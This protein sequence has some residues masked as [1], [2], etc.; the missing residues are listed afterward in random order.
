MPVVEKR[1]LTREEKNDEVPHAKRVLK[2]RGSTSHDPNVK[3]PIT[4]I[5]NGYEVPYSCTEEVLELA[6]KNRHPKDRDIVFDEEPHLYYIKG[7]SGYV[8]ATTF[9]HHYFHEFDS[10]YMAKRMV[11]RD[12][13]TTN[14]RYVKYQQ[15]NINEDSTKPSQKVL[16]ERI[17]QSWTDNANTQSALGTDMHRNI[18]LYYNNMDYIGGTVEFR[19][20][21]E[22]D[23]EIREE[24][25]WHPFRTEMIVWDEE[26]KLCGSIDMLYVEDQYLED[27]EEW[28]R[29]EK[30]LHVRIIDWKRSKQITM[31]GF[32][33]YGKGLCSDMVDCNYFH[34]KLQLNLY[35]RIL[36][37]NYDVIIDSIAILVCHPN[38]DTFQEYI[39]G[40]EQDRIQHMFEERIK[41]FT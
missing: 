32:G 5:V 11:S 26:V 4:K 13:F 10:E 16:V 27:I 15:Y 2:S 28:K 31:N 20:F 14:K 24:R 22:F 40:D 12:D 23:K 41:T 17:I 25:K 9:I 29:G 19:Y 34:Y 39:M 7:K 3:L 30:K 33:K 38:S 1:K 36:E 6:D 37:K 8:S 18:E 21:E 35:K